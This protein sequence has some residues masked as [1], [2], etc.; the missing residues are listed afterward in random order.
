MTALNYS[1]PIVI[2]APED[3]D[4]V[5]D[6]FDDI[7][8][9]SAQAS[10]DNFAAGFSHY[11]TWKTIHTA[12]ATAVESGGGGTGIGGP[13]PM[14]ES[15]GGLPWDGNS[16]ILVVYDLGSVRQ[17]LSAVYFDDADY[18]A[19]G[20]TQK[21]RLRGVVGANAVA[22][23]AFVTFG[24]GSLVSQGAADQLFTFVIAH[25]TQAQ[26]TVDPG[27]V[28]QAVS[29]EVP[30]PSDQTIVLWAQLALVLS[31]GGGSDPGHAWTLQA[32]LQRRWV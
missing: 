10:D 19:T 32:E 26:V 27:G 25:L 7:E 21:L 13:A 1:N 30:A 28:A 6:H 3:F 9:W 18:T 29:V 5:Q 24:L 12:Q 17:N 16:S 20:R 11:S 22:G 4:V 31:S 8:T 14:A 15:V 2:N 23:S